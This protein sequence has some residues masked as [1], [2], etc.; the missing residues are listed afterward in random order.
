MDTSS[1]VQQA[2]Q[3]FAAQ[4][5]TT[6]VECLEQVLADDPAHVVALI[7][8]GNL[9][10]LNHEFLAAGELF[11]QA[12]AAA[13]DAVEARLGLAKTRLGQQRLDEAAQ[14]L[15]ALRELALTTDQESEI[16]HLS[17]IVASARRDGPSAERHF[18]SAIALRPNHPLAYFSLYRVCAEANDQAGSVEVLERLT[19]LDP[20]RSETWFRLLTTLHEMGDRTRF[21]ACSNAMLAANPGDPVLHNLAAR[22]YLVQ[23][24]YAEAFLVYRALAAQHPEFD[25]SQFTALAQLEAL[26]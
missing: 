6:A 11:E 18:R 7:N 21:K 14:G 1:L 22:L 13:P 17:G 5:T 24:R 15:D 23:R 4:D 3:A 8:L 10:L 19:N 26:Q 20:H 25:R 16:C 12:C 2:I 9:R